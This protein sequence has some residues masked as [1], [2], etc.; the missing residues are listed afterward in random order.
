V[1]GRPAFRPRLE[2][3]ED[4]AVPAGIA[5]PSGLVSWWTGDGSAAG[6]N[7]NGTLDPGERWV[8]TD[9]YGRYAFTGLGPGT[10]TVREV[11]PAGWHLVSPPTGAFSVLVTSGKRA[12]G[13]NFLNAVG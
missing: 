10:Y 7:G 5:P 11:V 13:L 12:G 2:A 4:R 1:L 9:A 6:L 8:V 3:L